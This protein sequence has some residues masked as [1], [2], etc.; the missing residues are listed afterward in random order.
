MD[1][2]ENAGDKKSDGGKNKQKMLPC[3]ARIAQ[4]KLEIKKLRRNI[5]KKKMLP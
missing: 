4:K 1:R 2:P 3:N 5:T